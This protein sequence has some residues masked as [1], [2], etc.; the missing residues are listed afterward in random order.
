M[1]QESN[2]YYYCVSFSLYDFASKFVG[3]GSLDADDEAEGLEVPY[4]NQ[5]KWMDYA[6]LE[7]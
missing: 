6:T 3:Y 4:I 1:Q 5:S 7:A 2:L